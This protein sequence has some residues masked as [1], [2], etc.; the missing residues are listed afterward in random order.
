[1]P[2]EAVIK[3]TQLID[4]NKKDLENDPLKLRESRLAVPYL[5]FKW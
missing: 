3:Q 1:M 2:S 4:N 5:V